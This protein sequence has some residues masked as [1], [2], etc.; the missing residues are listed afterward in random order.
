MTGSTVQEFFNRYDE[1]KSIDQSKNALIEVRR[2]RRRPLGILFVAD[3][4][5]P[6]RLQDLL[7]RVTELEDAYQQTRLDHDRETRFNRGVQIHEIE[8]MDQLARIKT[9]MVRHGTLA[10]TP[11]LCS[12]K[13]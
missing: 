3:F 2:R 5:P 9:I 13:L 11:N 7:R 4:S 12:W 6:R 8:L 10:P 1:V